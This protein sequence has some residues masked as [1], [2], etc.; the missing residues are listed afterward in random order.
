MWRVCRVSGV[1]PPAPR[2]VYTLFAGSESSADARSDRGTYRGVCPI[3][4]IWAA[5]PPAPRTQR[6]DESAVEHPRGVRAV[7]HARAAAPT[8][9]PAPRAR[10]PSA[11][12]PS[13]GPQQGASTS[14]SRAPYTTSGEPHQRRTAKPTDPPTRPHAPRRKA[15]TRKSTE[16]SAHPPAP[17]G[18]GPA[19]VSTRITVPRRP[20]TESPRGAVGC[21]FDALAAGVRHP[22]SSLR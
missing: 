10:C 3:D 1:S 19:T 6:S 2:R 9:R 13:T 8:S 7:L 21:T 12:L 5:P 4:D 18:D 17:D 15:T 16:P 14:W 22:R 11:P 20:S